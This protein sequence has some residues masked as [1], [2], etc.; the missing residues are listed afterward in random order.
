M[1]CRDLNKST[2]QKLT[3]AK[4]D[5][6]L[7]ALWLQ[8]KP[9]RLTQK[10]YQLNVRQFLNFVGCELNEVRIED[11]QGFV[12]MLAMKGYKPS[13]IKGKL[14]SIKSL[15]SFAFQVGFLPNNVSVLVKSPH[16]NLRT[17][18]MRIN[19]NQIKL[20][21]DNALTLR[22][23][24]I[25]K[26]LFLLGL[27]VSE[28]LNITWSDF[29]QDS[30]GIKVFIEGKG[31]KQRSLMVA[32]DLYQDLLKLK[33]E[34]VD[35]LFTAYNRK[36]P[37]HRDAVNKLLISLQKKLKIETPIHPHKFRH[38]HSISALENGCDIHLLSRSLG[39][40]SVSITEKYYLDGRENQCSSNFVSL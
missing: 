31:N 24:L 4:N 12:T 11:V 28:L 14:N 29:Y 10:Q 22:D 20:M 40:S 34:G 13:T 9:S 30:K 3:K 32:P 8:N 2:M 1:Y 21:V 23:K 25:I 38:E 37:L 19:H 6:E 27:R 7:I 35:Y 26:M 16:V 15:F 17:A 5:L 39:H 36:R 18:S 33:K